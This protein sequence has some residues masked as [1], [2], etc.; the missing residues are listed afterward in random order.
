M[1]EFLTR[2]LKKSIEHW[3][4][5]LFT[6]AVVAFGGWVLW[7]YKEYFKDWLLS[8]WH[9]KMPIWAWILIIS[10]VSTIPA[11]LVFVLTRR[12]PRKHFIIN[13]TD[14]KNSLRDW[15]KHNY[16]DDWGDPNSRKTLIRFSSLDR[17]LN[18]KKGSSK[19]YL[20]GVVKEFLH[21][22]TMNEGED[23]IEIIRK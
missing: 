14:V 23:T 13:E 21:W 7:F 18:L 20:N 3:I 5:S 22:R 1:R 4:V 8:T 9:V 6:M 16:C 2:I 19:N 17:S 15:F 12:F 11:I 10:G